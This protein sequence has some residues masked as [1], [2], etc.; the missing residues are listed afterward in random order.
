M[1]GTPDPLRREIPD[2]TMTPSNPFSTLAPRALAGALVLAL[3]GC[4]VG[5]N[6]HRPDAPKVD[7][8][9]AQPLPA[10]T[11]AADTPGGDAQ[12][13]LEGT[14]VPQRWWTAFGNAELD[15]RVRQALAASPTIA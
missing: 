7:R 1:P 3:A 6:Y 2:L 13:F 9:T 14:D 8:Y 12:R 5:P 15:R 4:A 11:A 10:Q